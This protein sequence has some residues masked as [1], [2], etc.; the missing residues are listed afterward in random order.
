MRTAQPYERLRDLA[1]AR[2]RAD[3]T[4]PAIFIAA[5]GPLAEHT[6]RAAFARR[7][8]AAGGIEAQMAETAPE[9]TGQLVAAFKAA[10]ARIAVLCGSDARYADEAETT[11]RALK[12]AGVQRLYLAGRPGADEK[13]WRAAGIDSFIHIGVDVIATLELAHAE[14]GISS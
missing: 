2:T 7:F 8:F 3:G 4:R 14:L 11:A 12:D 1:D 9:N 13:A 5:L 6:A 10:G